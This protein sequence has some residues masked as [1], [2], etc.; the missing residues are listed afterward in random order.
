MQLFEISYAYKFLGG[1]YLALSV[2][3][4]IFFIYNRSRKASLIYSIGLLLV[5]INFTF[6]QE[7][8][9]WSGAYKINILT[10]L[11]ANGV[12]LFYITNFILAASLPG[13]KKIIRPFTWMYAAGIFILILSSYSD[14]FNTIQLIL[15]TTIYIVIGACCIIGL[16][17]KIANFHLIV[18]ATLLLT[19]MWVFVGTDLFNIWGG[20]Y[21]FVRVFFI[22]I[23]FISPFIAYSYYLSRYLSTT[24]KSLAREQIINEQLTVINLQAEKIKELDQLKSHFFANISHEFRTPLTLILSP[25]EKRIAAAKEPEDKTEFSLMHRNA[26]RLL[27]LVNQ[28]LDLSRLESGSVKLK[29]SRIELISFVNR[30][31]QAFDSLAESKQISYKII[32]SE[33]TIEVYVDTEKLDK[34]ITNLLSNALKF[35]PEGGAVEVNISTT[36]SSTNC[37]DGTVEIKV[38][39]TGVGI[40]G[41]QLEKIF[42]RFYQV[43]NSQTREYEGTGIGLALVKEL[44]DLQRGVISVESEPG[45]GSCFTLSLSL[46][47]S[48]LNSEEIEEDS[49]VN[50]HAS[51]PYTT[52]PV[53]PTQVNGEDHS[54]HAFTVLIAEDNSDLRF[55]IRDHFSKQYTI[56]EAADGE[57]ALALAMDKIPDLIIS[58][59]MMPKLDGIQLC[60]KLKSNEKTS[61]IPIIILTA[62]TNS[63]T[64][65]EGL[66]TGADDYIGKPFAMNELEVRMHNLIETR[67]KL[68]EKYARQMTMQPG[69]VKITSM[70]ERFLKKIMDV[71]ENHIADTSFGV[72]LFAREVAMSQVQLY[73]KLTALTAHSPNDFIRHIRLQRAAELLK[74][75]AGNVTEVAYQVGFNNLSYFS[76]CF[77]ETFGVSPKE[78]AGNETPLSAKK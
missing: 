67:K 53:L 64:K 27:R 17:K 11:A 76:K 46:G 60:K 50:I 77:R 75:K 15:R 69:E 54:I 13:L 70:D 38:K 61:H 58:D 37:V 28:L 72:E 7:V 3:H 57:E 29:I 36:R 42:D 71:V 48:H 12:L 32:T 43:N 44:V 20:H 74:K 4:I 30:T 21:P 18:L 49:P 56:L 47:C 68:Q 62:K 33:K 6:T 9:S 19:V 73:R 23:G 41:D 1:F 51:T 5:F 22:L 55:Y 14:Y 59:L 31:A 39:D 78:Y 35:T 16:V 8:E 65:I 45:K 40:A 34:I 24:K 63:E 66:E 26:S 10:D 2:L 25:L 52:L